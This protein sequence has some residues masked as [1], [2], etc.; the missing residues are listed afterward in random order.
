MT[1]EAIITY[2]GQTIRCQNVTI[3]LPRLT[4]RL[5]QDFSGFTNEQMEEANRL[6]DA[7]IEKYKDEAFRAFNDAHP[8]GGRFFFLPDGSI[9]F[10]DA[11]PLQIPIN[12]PAVKVQIARIHAPETVEPSK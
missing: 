8:N 4:P 10:E 12:T 3:N 5:P 2:R 9:C 6:L 1:G 7:I 11:D